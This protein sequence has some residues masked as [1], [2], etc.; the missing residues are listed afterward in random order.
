MTNQEL[1]EKL[2]TEKT[3]VTPR[4]IS[5]FREIDR[6]DFVLPANQAEAYE[7]RPLSI[8]HNATI[9]QP[10][11]V[12]FMLEKLQP[13]QGNKILEIGAGSGY[14]TALLAYIVGGGEVYS[15]EY[16][17]EL[18]DFAEENLKKYNFRNVKLFTGDGKI[19]L[20][21]RAPFD[22][23]ISSAS[24]ARIPKAWKSQLKR[25]ARLV[26]P[27]GEKM[28]VLDK[29]SKRKFRQEEISGFV[30]VPLR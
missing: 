20:P 22:R 13:E 5:A 21:D 23:I 8:G 18:K 6:K 4:I 26:A 12:A 16:V 19:G 1:V 3:L 29:I 14:M 2:I 30:F 15:I 24:G 17:P 28:V 10:T 11:T 27:V 9:S 7:D 25:G